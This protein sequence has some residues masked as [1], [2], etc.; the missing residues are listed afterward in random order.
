MFRFIIFALVPVFACSQLIIPPR[1]LGYIYANGS[2]DAIIHLDSHFGPL[3][4]DSKAAFP[5]L[6][7]VATHYGRTTL[8]LTLHMFPLPY[9]QQAYIAA[10][11]STSRF[12]IFIFSEICHKGKAFSSFVVA[13][14]KQ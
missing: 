7:E 5:V 8:K 2:N 4:P 9:H 1:P 12:V 3:C 11:V 10:R 6:Q 14:N 13:F